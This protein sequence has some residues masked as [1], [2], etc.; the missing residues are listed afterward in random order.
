MTEDNARAD[1]RKTEAK[2]IVE[3]EKKKKAGVKDVMEETQAIV[4][5][6]DSRENSGRWQLQR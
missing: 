5:A 1:V 4:E 3:E 2:L 6:E